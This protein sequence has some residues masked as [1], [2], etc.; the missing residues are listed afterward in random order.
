LKGSVIADHLADH[1]MEDYE[2]LDFNLRDED[3]LS[4]EEGKLEWW[5]MYFDGAVNV[6]GNRAGAVIISPDKKQYPV[7]I[8]LQFGCTNNTVEYEAC[9][10][11]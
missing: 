3:V 4:F 10:L 2:P 9:I 6:C 1:A 7:S 5:T 11:G 8:K